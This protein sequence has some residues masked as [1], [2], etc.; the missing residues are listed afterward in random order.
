MLARSTL[1][2]MPSRSGVVR[3][4]AL[5]AAARPD[6]VESRW[7]AMP[8]M[9]SLHEQAGSGVSTRETS[10]LNFV[11]IRITGARVAV[12]FLFHAVVFM[13]CYSFAYLLRFE[14]AIPA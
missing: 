3:P 6:R 1:T 7:Q 13:A 2:R 14:F 4:V 11:L 12:L 9:K 5:A 10:L 8:F